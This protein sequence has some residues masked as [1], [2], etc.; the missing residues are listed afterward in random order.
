LNLSTAS[1][2]VWQS[3]AIHSS[4]AYTPSSKLPFLLREGA[5]R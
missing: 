2:T 3:T 5:D 4:L 1:P